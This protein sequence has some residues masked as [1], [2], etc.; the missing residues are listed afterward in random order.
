MRMLTV[1]V[2]YWLH[3]PIEK[4]VAE[5]LADNS[6]GLRAEMDAEMSVSLS[7]DRMAVNLSLSCTRE[8]ALQ[9]ALA[10]IGP[11]L[12]FLSH[13]GEARLSDQF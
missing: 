8:Q 2:K 1:S 6:N 12:V 4:G 5:M 9:D 7:A 11:L 3:E 10:H 13:Y